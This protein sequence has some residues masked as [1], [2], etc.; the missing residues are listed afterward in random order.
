MRGKSHPRSF[1]RS[2]AVEVRD[3]NSKT[4]LKAVMVL[5]IEVVASDDPEQPKH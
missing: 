1:R 3:E 5:V 2:L 4:L